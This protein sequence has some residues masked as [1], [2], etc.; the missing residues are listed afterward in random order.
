[1][2]SPTVANWKACPTTRLWALAVVK[3]VAA[4]DST[5]TDGALAVAVFTITTVW[6][7]AS[8]NAAAVVTVN[9]ESVDE[10]VAMFIALSGLFSKRN[11]PPPAALDV[12]HRFEPA[13]E[14]CPFAKT[15][16]APPATL[17]YGV[18]LLDTGEI[19]ACVVIVVVDTVTPPLHVAGAVHELPKVK[20]IDVGV[21]HT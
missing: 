3:T 12:T 16:C 13:L 1:M 4:D 15:L 7:T 20:V 2:Q 19:C 5:V 21:V 6:P 18:F 11:T 9:A 8:V 17:M 14:S 10:M